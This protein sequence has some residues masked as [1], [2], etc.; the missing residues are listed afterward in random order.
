MAKD[1][2]SFK[3]CLCI[4]TIFAFTWVMYLVINKLFLFIGVSF[5]SLSRLVQHSIDSQ[6]KLAHIRLM[7]LL[8]L[9]LERERERER[10]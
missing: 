7:H 8:L 3:N 1:S 6:L 4:E 9:R 5:L 10:V 2:V